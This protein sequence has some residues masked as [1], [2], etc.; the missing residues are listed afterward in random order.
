MIVTCVTSDLVCSRGQ[1]YSHSVWLLVWCHIYFVRH[2]VEVPSPPSSLGRRPP[3]SL[4]VVKFNNKRVKPKPE[5]ALL[6]QVK[7]VHCCTCTGSGLLYLV[8]VLT[9]T[10]Q[11]Y[12]MLQLLH[13][14]T[15]TKAPF[16]GENFWEKILIALFVVIWQ[17]LSNHG[18]TRFKR[19]VSTFTGN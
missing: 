6:P 3:N 18:L 19:F 5:Y 9:P 15:T 12:S 13:I 11:V 16:S 10:L 8:Q 2:G 14:T 17:N 4:A 7:T 1:L